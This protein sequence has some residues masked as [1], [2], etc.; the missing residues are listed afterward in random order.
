MRAESATIAICPLAEISSDPWP[1][2][3]V[4]WRRG[5]FC[6]FGWFSSV[7]ASTEEKRLEIKEKTPASALEGIKNDAKRKEEINK[8]TKTSVSMFAEILFDPTRHLAQSASHMLF[9]PFQNLGS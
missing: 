6:K 3:M 4:A 1:G 2:E 7:S 8:L 5:I 9:R